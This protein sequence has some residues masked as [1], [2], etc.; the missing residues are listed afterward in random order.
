VRDVIL[1]EAERRLAA[2]GKVVDRERLHAELL[3][4]FG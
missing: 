3:R 4:E 2:R 1:K